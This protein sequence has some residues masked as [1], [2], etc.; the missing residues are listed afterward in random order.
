MLGTL[1]KGRSVSP[2]S[3]PRPRHGHCIAAEDDEGSQSSRIGEA[4]RLDHVERLD[5]YVRTVRRAF[6]VMDAIR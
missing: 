6:G 1:V 4:F 3:G 2:S 5:G